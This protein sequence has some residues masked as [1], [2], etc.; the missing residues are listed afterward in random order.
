[1]SVQV[2]FEPEADGGWHVYAPGVRGCRSQGRSIAEARGHI[3]EA[4]ALCDDVFSDAATAAA[5]V[6]LDE[7]IRLP[8]PLRQAVRRAERAREQ[9]VKARA[10]EAETARLLTETLSLRDAGEVLG[11]S[12][13][14]VRRLKAG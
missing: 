11:I 7:D 2:V 10:V 6:T 4:L 12:Q 14:G 1:V 13:E 9:A 5:T 3:R 8:A